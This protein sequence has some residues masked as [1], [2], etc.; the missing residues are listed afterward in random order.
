MELGYEWKD[1]SKNYKLLK[2][3]GSGSFGEVVMARNRKTKE[4]C[5]LKML[6]LKLEDMFSLRYIIREI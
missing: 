5:A 1:A 3:I 4:I 2:F 6:Q